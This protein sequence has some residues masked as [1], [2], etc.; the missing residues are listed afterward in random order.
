M[1]TKQTPRRPRAPYKIGTPRLWALA[2]KRYLDG[3]S[4]PKVA[5]DL[6]LTVSAIRARIRREGWTKRSLAEARE[7]ETIARVEAL[8]RADAE[9]WGDA[10][11]HDDA[12]PWDEAGAEARPK[13]AAR[14]ALVMATRLLRQGRVAEAASASRVAEA[15]SRAALRLEDEVAVIVDDEAA[16]EAVRRKVLG[17]AGPA[18]A[19]GGDA[20]GPAS[21]LPGP[22]LPAREEGA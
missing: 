21:P 4:A 10:G 6:D 11:P 1:S 8:D 12:E 2:R 3:D 9:L 18:L 17:W 22:P 20:A 5:G 19:G 13:E 15:M 7:A 14:R 16:F